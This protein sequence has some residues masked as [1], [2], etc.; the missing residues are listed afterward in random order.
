MSDGAV[1]PRL[2]SAG[3]RDLMAV[4]TA[5]GG[6]RAKLQAALGALAGGVGRVR[7]GDL[8]AIDDPSRGTLLID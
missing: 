6:M 4:G 3:A 8:A 1:I 5:V 2:T 7:I